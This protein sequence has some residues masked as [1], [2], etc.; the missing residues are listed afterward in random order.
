M[1]FGPRGA[2]PV[3]GTCV[4]CVISVIAIHLRLPLLPTTIGLI[5]GRSC[6]YCLRVDFNVVA[7]QDIYWSIIVFDQ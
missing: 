6:T 7:K 5:L 1:R 4:D 2:V 3:W